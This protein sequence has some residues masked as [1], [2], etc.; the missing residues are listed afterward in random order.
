MK[1]LQQHLQCPAMLLGQ[2]L[3][4]GKVAQVTALQKMLTWLAP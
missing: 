1:R 4:L 3:L 2:Q